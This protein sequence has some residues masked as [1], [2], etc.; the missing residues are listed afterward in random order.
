RL[1]GDSLSPTSWVSLRALLSNG[2]ATNSIAA[3]S[4]NPLNP[5]ESGVSR[6]SEYRALARASNENGRGGCPKSNQPIGLEL[7]GGAGDQGLEDRDGR[8]RE[9]Q[10]DRSEHDAAAKDGDQHDERVNFGRSA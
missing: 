4:P 5:Q 7:M 3:N 6:A 9:Q 2:C 10:S 1:D 8:E